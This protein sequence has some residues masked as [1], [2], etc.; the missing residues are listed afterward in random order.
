MFFVL[1]KTLGYLAQP[2]TVICVLLI[3]SVL[4]KNSK[5]KK[6]TFWFAFTLLIV[7]SNDFIANEVM[8]AW[9]VKTKPF[10]TMRKY[11]L[12]IVLTGATQADLEPNDRVYFHKGVD[13]VVHTVQLYK[14]GLIEKILISGGTG[15]LV[16]SKDAPEA[17][18]F[19]SA[20]M[21]MG[22]PEDVIMIENE[23]RNTAESAIEVQ[24]LLQQL[25][26]NADDCLLV[27]SAFHMRRSLACYRKVGLNIE[28]FTTDFYSHQR[29]F[30]PDSLF[31]PKLDAII[32]WHKLTK[33]W[34]GLLAYKF[35]GYI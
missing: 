23:T 31:I 8:Q 5:W 20:M 11:K 35:A 28:S 22:V 6:W 16:T 34:A 33:E 29:N 3:V 12:A 24:K 17:D 10:N 9:E 26:Y 14:L 25:N 18:K 19:K 27:T 4:I 13:R 21:L 7:F 32:I 15:R 1:S 30:Y 2:F